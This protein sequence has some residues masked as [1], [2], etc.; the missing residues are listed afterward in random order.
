VSDTPIGDYALLSDCH[1]AA[2]VSRTGSVDWLCFQRFDAPSVF[3]RILDDRAGHFSIR[4]VGDVEVSTRY[5]DG[6]M[7][8]ETTFRTPAG[9]AV[10]VDAMALPGGTGH[11]LGLGAPGA[12]LRRVT[13][14][15][16]TVELELE[17]APRPEYGLIVPLLVPIDGGVLARGGAEALRLSSSK[18]LMLDGATARATFSLEE[19]ARACFALAH[20]MSWEPDLTTWTGAGI[21]GAVDETLAAWRSWSSKHHAYDGHHADLVASSGRVLQAL[22]WQPTGAMVAAPTTSLPETIGGERNWDYRYAWVRDASFTLEALFVA[23]C[24]DEAHHFFSWMA[25]AVAS[26]LQGGGELQIMFGVGGEHDLTERELGHLD[27]WRGSRPVRVGNGAWNQRQLDVYGE[28]LS[29]ALRFRDQVTDLDEPTRHFLADLA[30]AAAARWTDSDEGIWEVRGGRREFLYSKLMCW[31]ALECAIELGAALGAEERVPGW[32]KVRDEMRGAILERGWSESAGAF[33]QSFGSDELDASA[34]MIPIV[35]FLP[36]ADPR[37]T[38]TIDA[39][40]ERLTDERGLVYR[41]RAHDG[42]EGEEGSFLLCTFWLAQ[43]LAMAGRV[44]EAME[45]FER[46]IAYRNDVGLLS[47]EIDA[48]TGELLGNFPQAFSHIGLINAAAAIAR[49]Q[50]APGAAGES[51]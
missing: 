31:K 50:R 5:L 41:Y 6:S 15:G 10:L 27:G 43:A 46:A 1:S 25:T 2:L 3:G 32:T 11:D 22:T 42:L 19:G 14:T 9:T 45:V 35:G 18:P 21:H 38:A 44:K 30:D 24:P 20:R 17:Y 23:T 33:T 49:A 8:L 13:C 39:I 4:P 36:A 16:G 7:V 40:K 37:V 29:A 51:G 28:L 12:L 47:E 34:L 48:E 26:S